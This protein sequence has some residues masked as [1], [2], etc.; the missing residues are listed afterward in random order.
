MLWKGFNQTNSLKRQWL[1]K[2]ENV[3]SNAVIISVCF[4]SALLDCWVNP[5]RFHTWYQ[6]EPA[7]GW[8]MGELSGLFQ[9]NFVTL[10]LWRSLTLPP[11]PEHQPPH[12][13]ELHIN[14]PL[15]VSF[16]LGG[17]RRDTLISKAWGG[18][19]WEMQQ[20]SLS[21][22][23]ATSSSRKKNIHFLDEF[24]GEDKLNSVQKVTKM[25]LV[26]GAPTQERQKIRWNYRKKTS[27]ELIS[28]YS[29]LIP[30]W[31]GDL[32]S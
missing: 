18:I 12:I 25:H 31:T 23:G 29:R 4:G 8:V 10:R 9:N 13:Q 17:S 26:Q 20:G 30:C 22:E 3:M 16:F 15:S 28:Q 32:W 5:V 1:S 27:P 6:K 2:E 11:L 21:L 14:L 19:A 7:C 24:L